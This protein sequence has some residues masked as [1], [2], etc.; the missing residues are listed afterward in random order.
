MSCELWAGKIE[1]YVDNE[2]SRE[3]FAAVEEHLRT[4]P[5]CARDALSRIQLKRATAAAALRYTPSRDFR[6]RVEKSLRKDRKSAWA[7]AW[8]PALI[9][10]TAMVFVV[11]ASTLVWTRQIET[12][13][14]IAELVDLHVATMASAN[15]VDVVSTDRHTVKPWFQ[16]KLP[17][18]FNLPDLPSTQF[19]LLGGK[20]AYVDNSPAAQLLFASG[21]HNVSVFIAQDQ[22]GALSTAL[23][24]GAVRDR[25]FNIDAWNQ[26]G[27]RYV[28]IS[29]TSSADIQALADL[30]RAAARQ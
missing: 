4:C 11:V 29:D 10:A 14:A 30:L 1:A 21:K 16:G 15:P 3:H 5:G 25:G 17:F 6:L 9:A 2:G 28:A 23:L 20:V 12:R 26:N 7:L 8:R 18:S 13:Q 19:K 27:L 22:P 24:G